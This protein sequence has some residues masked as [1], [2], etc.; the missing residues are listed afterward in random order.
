[1]MIPQTWHKTVIDNYG[2]I[3]NFPDATTVETMREQIASIRTRNK[4]FI[5]F[6]ERHPGTLGASHLEEIK[7]TEA[8]LVAID[9]ELAAWQAARRKKK[10]N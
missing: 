7:S 2:S 10:T 3:S 4:E 5:D 8:E 1:M 6:E 9:D